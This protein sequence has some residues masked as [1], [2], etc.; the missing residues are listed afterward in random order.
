[1]ELEVEHMH[2]QTVLLNGDWEMSYSQSVYTGKACPWKTGEM[3]KNAVPGYWE[4]MTAMFGEDREVLV[5]LS[6]GQ[7][8]VV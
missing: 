4:E 3:V 8:G 2:Y 6:D 1:M 5:I 7:E